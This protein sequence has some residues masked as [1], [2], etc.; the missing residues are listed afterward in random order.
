ML[1]EVISEKWL[2]FC[3]L[4]GKSF[5]IKYHLMCYM[6]WDVEKKAYDA[7]RLYPVQTISMNTMNLL[8]QHTEEPFLV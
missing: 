3:Q 5:T 6:K 8:C 2:E 4:K 7:I 1:S